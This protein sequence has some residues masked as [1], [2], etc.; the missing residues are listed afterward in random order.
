MRLHYFFLLGL[1]ILLLACEAAERPV[2]DS[3][4]PTS[5]QVTATS[6]AG[7]YQW[8]YSVSIGSQGQEVHTPENSGYS[9]ELLISETLFDVQR[10]GQSV[11]Y[12]PYVTLIDSEETPSNFRIYDADWDR[13]RYRASLIGDELVLEEQNASG[14]RAYYQRLP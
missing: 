13:V 5:N 3:Q 6:L 2:P 14:L 11:L 4:I 9:E 12:F 10:N 7:R 8:D 1:G